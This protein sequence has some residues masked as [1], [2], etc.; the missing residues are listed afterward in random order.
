MQGSELTTIIKR[1]PSV[2]K[3]FVGVFSINTVPSL[4]VGD[5]AIFN[6]DLAENKGFHWLAVIRPKKNVVE[7]FDSLGL[8]HEKQ[9]LI[10]NYLVFDSFVTTVKYNETQFQ[11]SESS[12]CGLYAVYFV[13]NRVMNLD[14]SFTKFLNLYFNLNTLANEKKVIG[15]FS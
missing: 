5:F 14:L 6:Q 9:T 13:I 7:C 4:R 1:Y 12:N 11:P 2:L 8:N 3:H 10:K 15:F